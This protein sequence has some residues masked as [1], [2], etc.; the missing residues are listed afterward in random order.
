[1]PDPHPI[2][3]AVR[4]L[5]QALGETQQQFAFRTQTAIRTIA[6]YETTRPPKGKALVQFLEL[7]K[8]NGLR[9]ELELFHRALHEEM[10]SIMFPENFVGPRL[11]SARPT[12]PELHG[13]TT[14]K[15]LLLW[16]QRKP[17]EFVEELRLW[18]EISS[19]ARDEVE[20]WKRETFKIP[21]GASLQWTELQKEESVVEEHKA[22]GT[23]RLKKEKKFGKNKLRKN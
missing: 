4:K 20:A 16:M 18:K 12:M 22:K 2:S 13:P 10:L 6:R 11:I 9:E 15:D 3:I 23:R 21:E 8:A 1:M 5:R 14:D 17:D 19:K 7:A